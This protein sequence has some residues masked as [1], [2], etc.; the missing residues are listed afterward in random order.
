MLKALDRQLGFRYTNIISQTLASSYLQLALMARRNNH[1]T[2]AG[3]HFLSC[4][5]K[6]GWDLPGSRRT[7]IA[8]AAYTVIGSWYKVFSRSESASGR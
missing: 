8:L 4:L 5:W 2:E 7:L 1:R 3:K 6:G